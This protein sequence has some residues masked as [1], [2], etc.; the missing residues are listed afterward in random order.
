MFNVFGS[1]SIY[2]VSESSLRAI[3]IASSRC[4]TDTLGGES[5]IGTIASS[6]RNRPFDSLRRVETMWFLKYI[7]NL[8]I[9]SCLYAYV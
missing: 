7:C 9:I 1:L 8:L 4:S 2:E 6:H 3:R 5:I